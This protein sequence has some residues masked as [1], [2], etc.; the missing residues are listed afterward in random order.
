MNLIISTI[1]WG[2]RAG[3][4]LSVGLLLLFLGA[5][6]TT[7]VTPRQIVGFLFF[8]LGVAV[9]LVIGWWKEGLGG[10]VSMASLA[11]F[12][13][14]YGVILSDQIPRGPWFVLFTAP[15]LLFMAV[16]FLTGLR[17]HGKTPIGPD[18][19]R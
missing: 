1:R 4:I 15:A 5:E 19:L 16:P 18:G 7:S 8:P 3:S 6:N 10:A 12:Y 2:A 11:C 17:S 9:G 13:L 14:V